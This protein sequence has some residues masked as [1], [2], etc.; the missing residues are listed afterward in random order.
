MEVIGGRGRVIPS[1]ARPPPRPGPE[2]RRGR[3]TGGGADIRE[4]GPHEAAPFRPTHLSAHR[5]GC[6]D[7][8]DGIGSIQFY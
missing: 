2:S 8:A 5:P 6:P 4:H 1:R 7:R 3:R